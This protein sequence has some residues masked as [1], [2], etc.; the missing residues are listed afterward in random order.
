MKFAFDENYLLTLFDAC[1]YTIDYLDKDNHLLI[2]AREF[3]RVVMEIK[4]PKD[5]CPLIPSDYF[6]DY[7]DVIGKYDTVFVF[8]HE[9]LT[10][11]APLKDF[12]GES[13]EIMSLMDKYVRAYSNGLLKEAWRKSEEQDEHVVFAVLDGEAS[14]IGIE[15]VK[16]LMDIHPLLGTIEEW[17]EICIESNPINI[18]FLYIDQRKDS[19]WYDILSEEYINWLERMYRDRG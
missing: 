18:S 19:F 4:H 7:C 11:I 12:E 6:T 1:S 5:I 13:E 15:D 16:A 17:A 8:I 9:S 10:M 14:I 3:P 2:D